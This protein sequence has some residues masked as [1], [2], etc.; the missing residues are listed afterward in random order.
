MGRIYAATDVE[1]VVEP[2]A[3]RIHRAD[4]VEEVTE[5]AEEPSALT[6]LARGAAQGATLNF[7]D[8]IVGLGE[9]LFS[10][11]TL[12]PGGGNF[13]QRY[14]KGR[15]ES[16]AANAAAK[17][18][19]GFAYGAG[20]LGGGIATSFVPG[21]GIAKGASLAKTA[22]GAA[23]LG[24]GAGLG[25]SESEDIGGQLADA[26]TSALVS[27]GTAGLLGRVMRGAPDRVVK[28][29]LGDLTDGA[30]ATQRD[31]V[32]GKGG[33]RVG[34]VVGILGEKG[35]KKAGRDAGRLL[36]QTESA[37]KETGEAFG[38]TIAGG[39][40]IRVADVLGVVE[41]TAKKLAG[42]PGKADLARAVAGKA[43]DVLNAW[44]NRT[45]VS[46]QEVQTLASDI[47]DAAFR[48]SP[49]VAPKAGQ[50][51][52]REVW[53]ELKGLIDQ[54]LEASTAGASKEARALG[55]R[56]SNLYNMR[57]AVRYKATRES[58]ESTRLKDRISGGLDMGLALA[59]PTTFVAKKTY[60]FVGKPLV[61]KA[62]ERLAQLVTAAQNGSPVAK[63]KERALMLGFSQPVAGAL[64]T[65]AMKTASEMSGGGYE[66]SAP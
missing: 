66:A 18:A 27:G 8:E 17:N 48:G 47:A 50:S 39:A 46:P 16:R 58:T 59:D 4:E 60:D 36:E 21:L 10:K 2:T 26:G 20:E 43:D 45:H 53:G 11:E 5:Q 41:T 52:S 23:K 32:V 28:R 40:P 54:S 29:A 55:R 3:P 33:E 37:I 42:D 49:A 22:L 30:T 62:D 56:M 12:T 35:F 57:E 19:H 63:I 65:W 15:D 34:E 61:R 7:S 51:T 6:A 38:E 13:A 24:A 64:S 44:G 14:R 25:A 9:A 31:R 1:E